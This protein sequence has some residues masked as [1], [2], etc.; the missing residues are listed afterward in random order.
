MQ[1]SDEKIHKISV[2]DPC[3]CGSEKSY[4]SCFIRDPANC[5]M[6]KAFDHFQ[7]KEHDKQKMHE[8]GIRINY[9]HPIVY[10]GKKIWALGNRL[11]YER[12]E[13]ET[14]H[15]FIIFVLYQTLGHEWIVT[16]MTKEKPHFIVQCFQ[17]YQE[18]IQRVGTSPATQKINEHVWSALPD[19]WS[20][21]LSSLAFDIASL[22][23]TDKLPNHLINRLKNYSEYQGARYEITV[24]AIF[25][26]LGF[27]IEYLDDNQRGE[28]HCEFYAKNNDLVIAVE[29]KSKQRS[30][31]LHNTSPQDINSLTR[32]RLGE[33]LNA[34]LKKEH[35]DKIFIIFI[36]ANT[37][38][39]KTKWMADI[40]KMLDQY[41]TPTPEQ[42]DEFNALFVTNFSPHYQSEKEALAGENLRV[43]PLFSKFILRDN[44]LINDIQAALNNYGNIP[45]LDIN[46]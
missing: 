46:K 36:D 32:T 12:P 23:H 5:S 44:Q 33:L 25:A 13:N 27:N 20:R 43:Q 26:R 14:F 11:Y 17:K 7:T 34:A 19:G 8:N 30:G 6:K 22:V 10:E 41:P 16:E 39:D 4:K 24:S 45:N 28:K 40:K 1:M 37:P 15:E 21:S 18:W 31:I 35:A 9:V 2:T 42:P 3:P 29:A 38:V